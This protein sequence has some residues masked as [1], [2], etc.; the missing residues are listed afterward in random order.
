MSRISGID[1][2][3]PRPLA[4]LGQ[5][6]LAAGASLA[7]FYSIVLAPL[8]ALPLGFVGF[9]HGAGA[10]ASAAGAAIVLGSLFGQFAGVLVFAAFVAMPLQLLLLAS[11]RLASVAD[12]A[13]ADAAAADAA[14]ADAPAAAERLVPLMVC[15]ALALAFVM[16]SAAYLTAAGSE[17]G[18]PG[19]VAGALTAQLSRPETQAL[20][21]SFLPAAMASDETFLRQAAHIW[22]IFYP[23][24]MFWLWLVQLGWARELAA[25]SGRVICARPLYLQWRLP[26]GLEIGL[27]LF[28]ALGALAPA[29][30]SLYSLGAAALIGGAYV[31][32]GFSLLHLLVGRSTM[33]R[34]LLIGVYALCLVYLWPSALVALLGLLARPLNLHARFRIW[35]AAQDGTKRKR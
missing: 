21:Q 30:L 14:A 34:L 15:G 19:A 22:L 16:L 25:R 26:E 4:L 12:A 13:A 3:P 7:C 18:L 6:L 23:T 31:I 5:I 17:G 35:V 20:L 10:S 29:A 32:L 8:A 9:R 24:F 11:E 1:S 27:A 33:R 28:L 2:P